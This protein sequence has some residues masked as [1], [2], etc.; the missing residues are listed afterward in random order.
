P[1]LQRAMQASSFQPPCFSPTASGRSRARTGPGEE[2]LDHLRESDGI[3]GLGDDE[4]A[5]WVLRVIVD[6]T[7]EPQGWQARVLALFSRSCREVTSS[8]L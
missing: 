7:R 3:D 1:A 5:A 4:Q 6:Y 2:R 8:S